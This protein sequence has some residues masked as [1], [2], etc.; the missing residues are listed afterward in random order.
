MAGGGAQ[1][2][3]LSELI[4]SETRIPTQVLDDPITAVVRGTGIILEDMQSM[5]QILV[6]TTEE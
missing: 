6:P 3:G 4:F 5:A 1:F 2:R